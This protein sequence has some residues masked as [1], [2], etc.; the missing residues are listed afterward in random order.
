MV[1]T[2]SLGFAEEGPFALLQ[3]SWSGDGT[4][5]SNKGN[6]ERIRCRAKY[7]VSPSGQNLDQQLTCASDSYRFDVSS[8]L[9]RQNDGSIAGKWTET[10]RNVTGDV[11]ARQDG[12]AIAA[13]ISGPSFTAQMTLTTNGD[14]QSV[15]IS[16]SSGDITSV[17]IS[18]KRT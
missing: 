7:F 1:M 12:D 9:V 17:T 10:N 5:T 14:E 16:P 3:G 6:T 13:K 2:P 18:L 4:I 11:S 15:Q 8:G